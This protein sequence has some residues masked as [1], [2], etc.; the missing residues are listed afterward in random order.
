MTQQDQLT[1]LYLDVF[2]NILGLTVATR[3][4][5]G[6]VGHLRCG[7][8]F[9]ARYDSEDSAYLNLAVPFSADNDP[10]AFSARLTEL[11]LLMKGAKFYSVG[12]GQYHCCVKTLVAVPRSTPTRD[13]LAAILPRTLQMLNCAVEELMK[14]EMSGT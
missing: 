10:H 9:I 5:G 3:P 4:N 2:T 11:N 8:K 7:M 13:H 12:D 6:I 1:E 14:R